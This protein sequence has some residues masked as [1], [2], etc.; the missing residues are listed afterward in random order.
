MLRT[1]SMFQILEYNFVDVYITDNATEQTPVHIT[2][3]M[4]AI[5]GFD[6]VEWICKFSSLLFITSNSKNNAFDRFVPMEG[7]TV[8]R[9]QIDRQLESHIRSGWTILSVHD[10][11]RLKYWTWTEPS[12]GVIAWSVILPHGR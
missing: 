11:L 7:K 9:I 3:R 12:R 6:V 2:D 8:L 5:A 1:L 10:W 4:D